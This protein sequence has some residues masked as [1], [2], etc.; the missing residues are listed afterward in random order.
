MANVNGV[1][2]L[3]F[4]KNV[5]GRFIIDKELLEALAEVGFE[6]MVLPFE[7]ANQRIIDK[8]A[9]RK[10]RVD[11]LDTIALIKACADIGL[12][13]SGN[14]MIG[15]P[16]ET[17]D[18]INNTLSFAR[19]HIEVG[20]SYASFF[21]PIPYPGSV[22]HDIAIREGYLLPDFNPDDM[23]WTKSVMQNTVISNDKLTDIR[24]NAWLTVNRSEYI[25]Y[26]TG[27]NATQ[28]LP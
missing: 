20:L 12:K 26:K 5:K 15:F 22:L 24:R 21:C 1:N 23:K 3:H 6:T 18:E 7:T 2:I 17:L 16:D 19:S 25:K 14:Y 11:K 10:L 13:V 27:M 28:N 4:F 8:Y 9:S